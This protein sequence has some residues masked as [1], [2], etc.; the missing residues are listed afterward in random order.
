MAGAAA[1]LLGLCFLAGPRFSSA[2]DEVPADVKDAI[3]K[4]A[5]LIQ[6][7]KMDDA[8][9]EAAAL[10]KK[11]NLD[12]AKLGSLKDPMH[13]FKSKK[14]G[15]IGMGP[16]GASIE[17]TIIS[18]GKAKPKESMDDI[19]KAAYITLAIGEITAA[20]TPKKDD[21]KKKVKDYEKWTKNMMDAAQDL[22][23]AAD[24]KDTKG[25]SAASK[26]LDGT[27]TDCHQTFR[28]SS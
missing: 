26:N 20:A 18:M 7:G 9:K 21:G 14:D 24:K 22:I 28:P 8:K 15:G 1:L 2:A 19:K 17:A 16:K 10:A 27:C 4:V 13:L 6:K 25:V 11:K 5:D 12:G 3:L 23:K